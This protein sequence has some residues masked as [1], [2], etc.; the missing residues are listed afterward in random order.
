MPRLLIA[1]RNPGKLREL[2]A[3]LDGLGLDLASPDDLV[4]PLEVEETGAD[5]AENAA[6]KARAYA[7][8]SGLPSLADDSG[9]EVEALGGAPGL[10]SARLLPGRPGK[11]P[12]DDAARR[13]R[14][15]EL[16]AGHPRPWPARFR[17]SAALAWP[18]GALVMAE[19]ECTGEIVPAPRGQGG[20]GY[21]PLFRMEGEGRTMAEL[22]EAVKNRISH[23]ARAV[24][25]LRPAFERLARGGA[26]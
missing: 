15:L 1:T 19:G 8:A 10:R 16:L 5:Y 25:A 26:L 2:R 4:L 17:C 12:A 3:L 18:T 11:T 6:R 13:L 7:A 23:R 9:L 24:Q 21:D 20:F 14:L 22:P